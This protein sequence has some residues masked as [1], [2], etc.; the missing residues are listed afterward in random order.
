MAVVVAPPPPPEGEGWGEG[1]KAWSR[2]SGMSVIPAKAG[3]H[4]APSP[5]VGGGLG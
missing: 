2:E 5:E 4:S 3:I 1:G